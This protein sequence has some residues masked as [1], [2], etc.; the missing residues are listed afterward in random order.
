MTYTTDYDYKQ[1]CQHVWYND[2]N[3]SVK[4]G[5]TV[6]IV[7]YCMVALLT[8]FVCEGGLSA[9]KNRK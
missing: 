6:Y 7:S 8:I 4:I 1:L 9:M 5:H 2:R 3:L